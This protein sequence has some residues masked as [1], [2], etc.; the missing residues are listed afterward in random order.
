M[1]TIETA[2]AQ[3]TTLADYL[4]TV[5]KR[6]KRTHA[7]EAIARINGHKSWNV[8]ESGQKNASSTAPRTGS[9]LA[10]LFV[11]GD[12]DHVRLNDVRYEIIFYDSDVLSAYDRIVAG[13]HD[14]H[15][16]GAKCVELEYIDPDHLI[17]EETLN[18]S[19]LAE[20]KYKNGKWTLEDGTTL[21]LFSSTKML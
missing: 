16:D 15:T 3:A 18:V 17:F 13:E 12:V 8:F 10:A 4:L 11:S 21:E 5:G 7:L 1:L 9:D 6:V 20:A 19:C 2:K 14:Q